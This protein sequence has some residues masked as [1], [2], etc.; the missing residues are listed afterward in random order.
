MTGTFN[1]TSIDNVFAL[2]IREHETAIR[3]LGCRARELRRH[4][5]CGTRAQAK[6]S[7]HE[8]VGTVSRYKRETPEGI[9]EVTVQH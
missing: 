9:Y 4:F 2:K 6:I 3:L 8:I 1:D 7:V 5:K